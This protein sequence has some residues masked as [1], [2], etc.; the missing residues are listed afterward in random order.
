MKT[1]IRKKH[2]VPVFRAGVPL[3]AKTVSDTITAVR[4]ER[5]RDN[6]SGHDPA[7]CKRGKNT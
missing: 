2:G 1:P 5:E 6:L 4:R 3:S 7:R